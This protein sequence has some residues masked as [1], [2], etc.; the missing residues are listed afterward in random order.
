MRQILLSL[1]ASLV[2]ICALASRAYGSDLIPLVPADVGITT[3]KSPSLCWI[4]RKPVAGANILFTLN[5]SRDMKP[6]LKVTLPGAID[7]DMSDTCRCVNLKHYNVQLE[8]DVQYYWF[9]SLTQN[10]DLHPLTI[11]AG[12]VIERC[13]VEECIIHDGPS[14]CDQD[15]VFSF[16]RS[17]IWYDSLSCLCELIEADPQNQK[18]RRLLDRLLKDVGLIP[19]KDEKFNLLRE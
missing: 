19:L 9:I 2:A 12:G 10:S 3:K 6:T 5:D 16:A 15:A 14:L 13:G 8:P 18:L 1:L 11:V 7:A 4:Q 17:G